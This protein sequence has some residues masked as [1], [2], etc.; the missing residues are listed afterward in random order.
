MLDIWKVL[1]YSKFLNVKFAVLNM[2][3]VNVLQP[4][5]LSGVEPSRTF[6]ETSFKFGKS[7]FTLK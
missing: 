4:E 1:S 6:E 7:N 2:Q 3:I 5:R